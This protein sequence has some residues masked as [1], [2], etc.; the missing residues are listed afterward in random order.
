MEK[1][2]KSIWDYNQA[3]IVIFNYYSIMPDLQYGRKEGRMK[4]DWKFF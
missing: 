2:F 3:D 4:R 1:R